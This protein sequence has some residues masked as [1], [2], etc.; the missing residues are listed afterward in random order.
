MA[1]EVIIE[2]ATYDDKIF[3]A[4]YDDL[5]TG[6]KNH[7]FLEGSRFLMKTSIPEYSLIDIGHIIA[8][9]KV[10]NPSSPLYCEIYQVSRD[11]FNKLCDRYNIFEKELIGSSKNIYIFRIEIHIAYSKKTQPITWIKHGNYIKY[12]NGDCTANT[13]DYVTCPH[14]IEED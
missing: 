14:K 12:I 10:K 9:L 5:M 4:I 1:S 6:C 13:N 8:A 2:E 3:V 11:M 7:S